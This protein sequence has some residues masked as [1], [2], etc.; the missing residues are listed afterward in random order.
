MLLLKSIEDTSSSIPQINFMNTDFFHGILL[1][2][3]LSMLIQTQILYE[4]N[5]LTYLILHSFF[6]QVTIGSYPCVV[7]ESSENSI[8]CHIDPQDSMDVGIREIVTLTVYNL[9]TAINTVPN[10]FDR[11]FVLLPNIDMVL[12]SAGSTTGMTRVTIHGSGFG[13][14]FA[15]VDVSMGDFPCK[16]LTVTYT[17]IE[18]ETSPAPQQLVPVDLLIHGVPSRCQ[19]N[20]S[21]SYQENLAPYVTGIFPN[22]IKGSGNLLIEGEGLGTLLED[23]SIFIGSQ[24]FRAI[25]VNE[26]NIT[27]SMTPLPAGLHSLHIVVGSKGLALGNLTVSSPAVAS[28]SP[29]TGSIAGGTTLAITGNGFSPGNTTVTIGNNP[30]Q[31]VFTN[32]SEVYC[33]T[34]AGRAGTASLKISVNAVAY[35]P[36]SFTYTMEDTPFLKRIIPNRGTLLYTCIFIALM[37]YYSHSHYYRL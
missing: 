29:T 31:I 18:C 27:V 20:C 3:I 19:G 12:P 1:L 35:P 5:V 24:Q 2:K 23:V 32:S 6:F 14:S 33:S 26:N 7:E 34:P 21:F 16:V 15:S 13:A 11:R 4:S 25:E 10:E 30:C 9:G 17:A 37:S 8:M 36:L 28:V 22:S